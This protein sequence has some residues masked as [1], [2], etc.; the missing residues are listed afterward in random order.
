MLALPL[1]RNDSSTL[2]EIVTAP[3]GIVVGGGGGGGGGGAG[4]RGSAIAVDTKHA[5]T[6]QRA[7]MILILLKS[8]A[9]L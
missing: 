8:G 5:V 1:M 4:D 6:I 2:D 9:L 3:F 7:R